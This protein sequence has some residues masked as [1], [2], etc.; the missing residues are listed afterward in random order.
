MIIDKSVGFIDIELT[1]ALKV[2]ANYPF[3]S[4]RNNLPIRI[5][6]TSMNQLTLLSWFTFTLAS[7]N[8]WTT[9]VCPLRHADISG[10]APYAFWVGDKIELKLNLIVE[11]MK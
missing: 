8:S 2:R 1:L 11:M 3:A 10:V 7:I 5:S 4:D 9:V 6:K